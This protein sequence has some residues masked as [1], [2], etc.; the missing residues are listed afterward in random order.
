MATPLV[1]LASPLT[2]LIAAALVIA[3]IVAALVVLSYGRLYI[4]ALSSGVHVSFFSLIGMT[5]RKVNSSLIVNSLIMAHKANLRVDREFLEGHYLARGNVPALV[6]AMIMSQQAGVKIGIE[7]LGAHLLAGGDVAAV[8]KALIA[9]G[10]AGIELSFQKACAIDLAGRDIVD[11]VNTSVDPRVIDCPKPGAGKS[12][13]DAVAKDGIQVK[14][15]ARVTVRTCIE[16]LVGGATDDTIIARV[17]EGI[18]SAIGSSNSYTEVLENPDRISNAVLAKGLDSGT[19]FEILSIDIADVDVGE[20]VG[21]K[22]D[23]DRANAKKQVAQAD[24]EKR[25]AEARATQAEQE[26]RISEM[27]AE[28]VKAEAQIPLAM[29]EA[30]RSGNLGIMDYYRLKNIEA[31]TDMRNSIGG[32]EEE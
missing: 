15:K 30:F 13:L 22:L 20:N 8:A 25:A 6:Q 5:L 9:A 1:L 21:A 26:A 27:R 4:Q 28:V 18:V 7:A 3:A 17:G 10:K 11:A 31:D 2:T 23:I 12:T 24:A 32:Q 16:R 19:A 29:A 14:A